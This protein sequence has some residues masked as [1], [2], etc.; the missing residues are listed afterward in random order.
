MKLI[1]FDSSTAARKVDV[2]A[3]HISRVGAI[4]LTAS[5]CTLLGVKDGDGVSLH[6]D[7]DAKDN[8]YIAKDKDGLKL[9]GK[10]NS[11]QLFFC[12]AVICKEIGSSIDV[13]QPAGRM[14]VG[15]EPTNHEGMKLYPIL[16]SSLRQRRSKK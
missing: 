6:Q 5:L 1:K 3:I 8:W 13:E 12:S 10:K 11:T 16:T 15:I 2:P 4:S 9:R 14:L 7:A